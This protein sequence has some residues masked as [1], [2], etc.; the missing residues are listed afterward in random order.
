M[1]SLIN[2]NDEGIKQKIIR[3]FYIIYE[4]DENIKQPFLFIIDRYCEKHKILNIDK[5]ELIKYIHSNFLDYHFERLIDEY[6]RKITGNSNG[7]TGNRKQFNKLMLNIT[8][9]SPYDKEA[10]YFFYQECLLFHQE[11]NKKYKFIY[12]NIYNLFK[13]NNDNKSKTTTLN[14]SIK[15]IQD[16]I[17]LSNEYNENKLIIINNSIIKLKDDNEL[18]KNSIKDVKNSNQIL[19]DDNELLKNYIEDIKND[20]EFIKNSIKDLMNSN[21]ILKDDNE[22]LK[23]SNQI[24]KDDNEFI[25][26]SIEDLKNSNQILK[27]DNE[28]IKKSIEDVKNDNEFFKKSIR[29]LN[30]ENEILII[31]IKFLLITTISIIITNFF[32]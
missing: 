30:E 3:C 4:N 2:P 22:F 26:N 9:N 14:K 11:E 23:K 21:K 25:K 15:Y 19:K 18:L 32:I 12:Y 13:F 6:K 1:T 31:K 7:F 29:K 5:D 27:D 20:N 28:F 8:I 17:K 10:F 16:K 24:L